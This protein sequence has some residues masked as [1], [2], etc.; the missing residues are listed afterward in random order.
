MTLETASVAALIEH[1]LATSEQ[2]AS[3]L[4]LATDAGRAG[5]LLVQRLPG[6]DAVDD[7]GQ[8]DTWARAGE[9]L[10]ADSIRAVLVAPAPAQALLAADLSPRR[11]ARIRDRRR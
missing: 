4:V 5:G 1:Y 6:V 7:P 9:R 8:D 10:G 2:L 3:R 11:R